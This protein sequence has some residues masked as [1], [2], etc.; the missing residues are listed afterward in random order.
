MSTTISAEQ[1]EAA[2]RALYE[3]WCESEGHN[4]GEW[5]PELDDGFP[6]REAWREDAR[7]AFRAAG[8]EV[9]L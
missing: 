6:R 2:A 5:G 8:L 4:L 3:H 1:V 7:V 9:A